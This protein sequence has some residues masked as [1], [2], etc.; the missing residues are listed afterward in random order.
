MNFGTPECSQC[1]ICG[2]KDVDASYAWKEDGK[3]LEDIICIQCN[4]K[5]EYDDD[6]YIK[7][8]IIPKKVMKKEVLVATWTPRRA[9]F[10]IPEGLD[11]EDENI[12]ESYEVSGDELTIEY[13]NGETKV[14][15]ATDI[16]E[17]NDEDDPEDIVVEDQKVWEKY[18]YGLDELFEKKL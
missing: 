8:N 1:G 10:K 16:Q 15:E 12:V 4:Q 17:A 11:L 3:L 2:S 6:K 13:V 9:I 18:I 7:K 14:I 5:W